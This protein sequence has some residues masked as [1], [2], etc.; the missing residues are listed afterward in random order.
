MEK[1]LGTCPVCQHKLNITRLNCESCHTVIEGMFGIS[2]LGQLPEEHQEFIE[3]FIKARGNI[4]EVE[5]ELGISYPTVRKRLNDAIAALGYA[6]PDDT[7][8]RDEIL[9]AVEAGELTAKEAADLIKQ[10]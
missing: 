5:K 10:T 6:P 4:K 9:D 8:R 1:I 3:V 2:K 7:R